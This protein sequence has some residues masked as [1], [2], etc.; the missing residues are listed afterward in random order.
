MEVSSFHPVGLRPFD[1]TDVSLSAMDDMDIDMDIDL[2]P[3]VVDEPTQAHIAL[4]KIHIRGVDDLT[5]LDIKAY[6]NEHLEHLAL[7]PPL[8]IEWIDDTSANIVFNCPAMAIK[9]L[10]HLSLSPFD[11]VNTVSR[12]QLRTAKPFSKHPGSNL[13]IRIAVLTDQKRPRAYEASRFYMMHPE[14]D[15]RERRQS[16]RRHERDRTSRNSRYGDDEHRR[17]KQKDEDQGFTAS[18]YDDDEDALA[19]RQKGPAERRGSKSTLSSD[20]DRGSYRRGPY[21]PNRSD[22]RRSRDRSASPDRDTDGENRRRKK[23]RTPPPRYQ[24]RDPYPA[25]DKKS[26][27]ELFPTKATSVSNF[28]SDMSM[29]DASSSVRGKELFPN[30]K[31]V[32]NLKKELFPTRT[33]TIAHRRSDAFDAAD[34]TADLFATGMSVPFVDGAADYPPKR[35]LADRISTRP[36][37]TLGRLKNTVSDTTI[38]ALN[39]DEDEGFSIRGVSKQ[40][41]SGFSIRGLGADASPAGAVKELFPGKT[42]GN[43]GKELFAEKLQG[44][45]GRRN[46]AADMFY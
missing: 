5:T 39:G 46:K 29:R 37:N 36:K 33:V 17:R 21:R 2:G 7:D 24:E 6:S 9:A 44:R 4:H 45:G 28:E 15:P 13:Q 19:S 25:F 35:S 40:Q 30:K 12:L 43:A 1:Q 14:H 34:E 20:G 11:N 22:R 16:G 32:E 18:M 3:V 31:T 10:H 41:D 8:R 23:R 27:K 38:D 26:G 42:V